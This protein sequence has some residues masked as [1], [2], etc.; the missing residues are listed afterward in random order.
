[1]RLGRDCSCSLSLA[2]IKV[3][4]FVGAFCR[5]LGAA[6][7]D[8]DCNSLEVGHTHSLFTGKSSP[9]PRLLA[10]WGLPCV[11]IAAVAPPFLSRDPSGPGWLLLGNVW[12]LPLPSEARRE[13]APSRT[14]FPLPPASVSAFHTGLR[15][16]AVLLRP[17][18]T[19]HILKS[20]I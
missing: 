7:L 13:S 4:S 14:L 5:L 18:D 10:F 6:I 8:L 20:L 16:V 17:S 15:G 1:M 12:Y 3:T 19:G 9:R 2:D 11:V